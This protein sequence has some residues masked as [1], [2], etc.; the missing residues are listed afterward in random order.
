M[1][2]PFFVP[3]RLLRAPGL[4]PCSQSRFAPEGLRERQGA[5]REDTRWS[6]HENLIPFSPRIY[7][8]L[9]GSNDATL[10][11]IAVDPELNL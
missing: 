11:S 3:V 9:I 8:I 6:E 2:S 5:L 10:V 1:V 7:L 4:L